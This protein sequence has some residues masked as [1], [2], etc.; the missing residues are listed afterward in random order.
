MQRPNDT[1][2]YITRVYV[3]GKGSAVTATVTGLNWIELIPESAGATAG[4]FLVNAT[5]GMPK[6]P[7]SY[8]GTLVF[9]PAGRPDRA[10]RVPITMN[11]VQGPGLFVDRPAVEMRTS[12]GSSATVRGFVYINVTPGINTQWYASRQNTTGTNTNVYPTFGDRP[13]LVEITA[14]PMNL[15]AGVY[16]ST[17]T[18]ESFQPASTVVVPVIVT[19]TQD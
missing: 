15:Q 2:G 16:R 19:I 7:G 12:T 9:A 11:I 18:F 1:G 3:D 8:S 10:A 17:V 13:M 14:R 5:D 4:W 6:M